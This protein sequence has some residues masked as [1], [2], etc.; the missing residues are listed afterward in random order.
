MLFEGT[1][2]NPQVFVPNPGTNASYNPR[3]WALTTGSAGN[4]IPILS[5]SAN[6]AALDGSLA[7]TSTLSGGMASPQYQTDNFVTLIPAGFGTVDAVVVNLGTNDAARHG[8]RGRGFAADAAVLL[9]KLASLYPSAKVFW[10]LPPKRSDWA[11][12]TALTNTILPALHSLQAA[13]PTLLY[14]V[15]LNSVSAGSDLGVVLGGDGVHLTSYGYAVTASL[16]ASA[17]VHALGL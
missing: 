14:L 17:I 2:P 6:I 12:N 8:N 16:F 15:D 9:A 1:L 4:A 10:W 7:P 3:V 5:D 11:G 13:N